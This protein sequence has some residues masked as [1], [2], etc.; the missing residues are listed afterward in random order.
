MKRFRQ[1]E[2]IRGYLLH[3]YF[4]CSA[5]NI[6]SAITAPS[7]LLVC[8]LTARRVTDVQLSTIL[9]LIHMISGG[10]GYI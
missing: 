7:V 4:T 8:G 5:Y 1:I 9:H 10:V 6:L 2:H 3:S